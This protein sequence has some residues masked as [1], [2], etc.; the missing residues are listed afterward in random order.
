M[1][2]NHFALC[3]CKP[4]KHPQPPAHSHPPPSVHLNHTHLYPTSILQ[5]HLLRHLHKLTL[6]RSQRCSHLHANWREREK[7]RERVGE[8]RAAVAPPVWV[9]CWVS[10]APVTH[11][12][13]MCVYA[14]DWCRCCMDGEAANSCSRCESFGLFLL[15]TVE[16]C[17]CSSRRMRVWV[18]VFVCAGIA[19]LS[20]VSTAAAQFQAQSTSNRWRQASGRHAPFISHLHPRVRAHTHTYTQTR[21]AYHPPRQSEL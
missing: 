12:S 7:T 13:T 8:P 16:L 3:S 11:V 10:C 15:L 5:M 2:E 6:S 14:G 9:S 18:R 1:K 21:K 17:E 4:L 19:L 20:F